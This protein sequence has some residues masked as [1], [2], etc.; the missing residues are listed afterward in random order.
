MRR[1]DLPEILPHPA[2]RP[3]IIEN[4]LAVCLALY[5][6]DWLGEGFDKSVGAPDE[7]GSVSLLVFFDIQRVYFTLESLGPTIVVEGEVAP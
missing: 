5:Y 2:R 1:L 4:P 3:Q 6:N 7:P